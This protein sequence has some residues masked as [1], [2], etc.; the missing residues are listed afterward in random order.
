[1]YMKR[2]DI[3]DFS[4][5][6]KYL[7]H[8]VACQ[9]RQGRGTK[10]KIAQFLNSPTSHISQVFGGKTHFTFEQAEEI[11]SFLQHNEDESHFFLLLVQIGRA[12][13]ANLKKRLEKERQNILKRRSFLKERLGVTSSVSEQDQLQFYSSW[14]YAAVHILTTIPRYQTKEAISSYLQLSQKQ[15]SEV[16][17]FLE[18]VHLVQRN[19][20]GGYEAGV[21][22]IHL[23]SDSHLISKFHTNWRIK[24]IQSFEK[25]AVEDQLHYSSIVSLAERDINVVKNILIKAIS[26]A[27]AVIKES[28]P[29]VLHSFNLDFFQV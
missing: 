3:F 1:M 5:Y 23:G 4:D 16:L 22:R 10:N 21:S 26:E 29:E 14:I 19:S 7:A 15:T 24:T 2:Q 20:R 8:F 9:P 13:S 25:Q 18:R 6:R 27:K 28:P 11:N 17:S 12:G